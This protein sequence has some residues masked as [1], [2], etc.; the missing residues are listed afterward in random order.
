MARLS[1]STRDRLLQKSKAFVQGVRDENSKSPD[2][3]LVPEKAYGDLER[4][5]FRTL[6]QRSR[7]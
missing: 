5:L 4:T 3:N 2:A 7:R 6:M 1:K